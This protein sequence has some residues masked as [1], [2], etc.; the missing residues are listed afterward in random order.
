MNIIRKTGSKLCAVAVLILIWFHMLSKFLVCQVCSFDVCKTVWNE[1]IFR[2]LFI[3]DTVEWRVR[4]R[5]M[6][7]RGLG[8][9]EYCIVKV[10][11]DKWKQRISETSAP[12]EKKKYQILQKS[13]IYLHHQMLKHFPIG[14]WYL[15]EFPTLDHS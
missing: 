1:C 3:W 8:T 13:F 5:E 11:A 2:V 7:S 9:Y 15:M 12:H 10:Y 14:N 6:E 4:G